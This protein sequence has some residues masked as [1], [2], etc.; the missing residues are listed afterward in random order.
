MK[1]ITAIILLVLSIF[2]RALAIFYTSPSLWPIGKIYIVKPELI[3]FLNII[4][5]IIFVIFC[6][7]VIK[8]IAH[9]AAVK[10]LRKRD[11]D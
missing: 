7:V 1:T 11:Y 9:R 10:E 2:F 6:F 3:Y 8:I 5:A 4:S